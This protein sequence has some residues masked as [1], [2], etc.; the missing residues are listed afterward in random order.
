MPKK[1][2]IVLGI[3][4]VTAV[5]AVSGG[6]LLNVLNSQDKETIVITS[7]N[8]FVDS[9]EFNI[10]LNPA[11]S[12]KRTYNIENNTGVTLDTVLKIKGYVSEDT[13]LGDVLMIKVI[14]DGTTEYSGLVKDWV[15][16]PAPYVPFT[17]KKTSIVIE[18]SVPIEVGNEYQEK[19]I[20]V[21]LSFAVSTI[22]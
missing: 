14:R 15:N 18:F 21:K 3:L 6:M 20:S 9:K 17:E 1:L 5:L 16:Q 22:S 19:G 11:E 13:G 10:A 4:C 12:V 7:Q 2:L 8:A